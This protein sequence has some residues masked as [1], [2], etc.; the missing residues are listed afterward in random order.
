MTT[1]FEDPEV[2][3]R[4]L[5]H[6]KYIHDPERPVLDIYGHPIVIPMELVP[7][8]QSKQYFG[9]KFC[10]SYTGREVI[11]VSSPL[12]RDVEQERRLEEQR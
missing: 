4:M 2:Q 10:D 8:A 3:K 12:Q 9:T 6:E 5:E 11:E 7:V 1:D